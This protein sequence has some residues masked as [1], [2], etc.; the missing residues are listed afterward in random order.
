MLRETTQRPSAVKHYEQNNLL[1]S[2][3]RYEESRHTENSHQS[4]VEDD[5]KGSHTMKFFENVKSSFEP[6]ES[7]LKRIRQIL[8]KEK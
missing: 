2:K 1:D 4:R 7:E 5:L 3:D 8:D 6:I